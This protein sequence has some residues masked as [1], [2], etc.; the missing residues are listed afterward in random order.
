[1]IYGQ[2]WYDDHDAYRRSSNSPCKRV[3]DKLK[4]LYLGEVEIEEERVAVI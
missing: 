2:K 3:L 1:M 4:T